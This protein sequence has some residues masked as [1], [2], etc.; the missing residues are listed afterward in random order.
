LGTTS[1]P[2][3]IIWSRV[4]ASCSEV[5]PTESVVDPGVSSPVIDLL[6]IADFWNSI[7]P[8]FYLPS[9]QLFLLSL[10]VSNFAIHWLFY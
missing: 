9:L 2:A 6:M 1:I 3:R 10:L 4:H 8:L 5:G 7:L